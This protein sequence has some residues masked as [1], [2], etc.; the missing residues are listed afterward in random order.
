MPDGEDEVIF[1]ILKLTRA[2]LKQKHMTILQQKQESI[3]TEVNNNNNIESD[4]KLEKPIVEGDNNCDTGRA[5]IVN[6]LDD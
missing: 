5:L 2:A 4:S 3:K 1:D 6:Y